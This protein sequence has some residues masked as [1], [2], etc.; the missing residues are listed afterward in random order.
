MSPMP[1]R[2]LP[3]VAL[4][5][6]M[7]F[8]SMGAAAAPDEELLRLAPTDANFVLLVKDLR[9]HS[10]ALLDSPFVRAY[11]GSKLGHTVAAM[12]ELAQLESVRKQLEAGL[13]VEWSRIRDD[14]LGDAVIFAYQAGPPGRP[15]QE[16]GLILTWTRDPKLADDLLQRLNKI[17]TDSGELKEV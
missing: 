1:Q 8:D 3:V 7:L 13:G 6:L 4:A 10:M 12:P 16:R 15:D 9:G 11:R 14:I 5:G 2:L 17:Q